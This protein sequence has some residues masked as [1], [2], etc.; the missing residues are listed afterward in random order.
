MPLLAALGCRALPGLKPWLRG[1]CRLLLPA[2]ER[3]SPSLCSLPGTFSAAA[4]NKEQVPF[5]HVKALCCFSTSSRHENPEYGRLIY[6][7]NL[8]RAVLGVKFFSY[9]TSMFSVCMVPIILLKTGVGLDSLP[10]QVAFYSVVGFFTFITPVTLHLI[11]KG[12]V[13]RLYHKAETDTYTA[14]TY[15]AILA[16]KKTV[17]HQ[18]DVKIPNISKMFTTFYAKTKSMLVNPLLFEYPQD[19][20][21]L[22]GYDKPFTFDFEE[23][24]NSIEDK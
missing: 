8:A 21:H 18:K 2:K 20:S 17:F 9:S 16:E 4:T 6:S 13:I 1:S 24:K 22:M 11:T 5:R 10:L 14:I 23:A 7:G 19:Y 12:Y 15:N 3:R